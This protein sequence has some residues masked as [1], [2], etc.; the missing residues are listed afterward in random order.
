MKKKLSVLLGN[1]NAVECWRLWVDG[2][3]QEESAIVV[4][5][6]LQA[7]FFTASTPFCIDPAELSAFA[8]ELS[9]L[10]ETLTGEARL[11]ASNAQSQVSAVFGVNELG[12]V[13]CKGVYAINGNRLE[14][15]IGTDQTQLAPLL[16][17]VQSALHY[18]E[19]A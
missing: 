11:H 7:G 12:H 9:K 4:Q 17:W 16:V 5:G 8:V 15:T 3:S 14:F 1:P 13:Q 18:F 19:R 10:N 6:E 2:V